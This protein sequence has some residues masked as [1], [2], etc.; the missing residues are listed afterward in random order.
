MAQY[1]KKKILVV[2]ANFI[3]NKE[4]SKW[5]YSNFLNYR[6]LQRATTVRKQVIGFM[7]RFRIPL[8]SCDGDVTLIQKCVASGF[9]A[10]AARLSP[11]GQ[12]RTLRDSLVLAIHPNSILCKYSPQWVVFQE[13]V[14]TT[15]TFM[16]DLTVIEQTW[17]PEIAWVF[18][19]FCN[20]FQV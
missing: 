12:Y 1:R 4:S 6:S 2:Y 15:K 13:V 9:F 10:N 7:R 19:L 20:V 11:D 16:K 14:E 17:L 3:S 8:K 5:C 18:L